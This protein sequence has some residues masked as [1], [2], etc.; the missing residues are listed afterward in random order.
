MISQD[1]L[2]MLRCPLDPTKRLE[3]HPEGLVCQNCGLRFPV[4]EG[5]PCMVAEDAVLPPGCARLQELPCQQAKA[6]K[7]EG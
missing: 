4:R 2:D 3:A 7:E 1:L 5:I 6:A